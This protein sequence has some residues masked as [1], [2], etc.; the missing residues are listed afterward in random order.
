MLAHRV[1]LAG[2]MEARRIALLAS[3][4][5]LVSLLSVGCAADAEEEEAESASE[6]LRAG[7][8]ASGCKRSPYNCGLN[9][10]GVGQRVRRA[11][12][13][14]TWNMDPKW[15]VSKG[16]V[17]AAT[18]EPVVPVLDGNGQEMGRT[19]KTGFVFNYGQTRRF[20]N[21]T[22][23]YVLSSGLKSAGW[24]PID[25][26][27]HAESFRSKVGEV[28]AK[29]GNLKKLGCYQIASAFDERLVEYKIVKGAPENG[30]EADDYLPIV[31]ANGK[32]Y[33]NLIFNVPG[34]GLGG[35]SIDIYPSGTK[36]QRVD[37]PTWESPGLPSLDAT[38]Y[39]K[40]P[41]AMTY[42]K[43]AGSMKFIY[44]YVK[45]KTGSIRYGWMAL[46]GLNPASNCPD[47]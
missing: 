36:F 29:G 8:N 10:E 19:K 38:L 12:G 47:R 13:E 2:I 27:L 18:K 35:P 24:V 20:G 37:V 23:A 39:T 34:D 43:P 21:M 42:A 1:Q 25:G 9:T 5:G 40:A 3:F 4:A 15:L 28:N 11:D 17:D 31:R 30:P 33:M 45:S 7:V 32:R 14:E 41:G 44:G 46:D 16:Y 6:E 22:Y 26:L